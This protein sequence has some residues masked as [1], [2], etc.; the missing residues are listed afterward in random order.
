MEEKIEI[1]ILCQLYG[2][3][4][5]KKQLDM[6]EDYYNNDLSLSEIAEN[7]S[8]TRQAV[9][10]VL[11]KSKSKLYEYEDKLHLK[12]KNEEKGKN[13]IQVENLLKKEKI[14]KSTIDR[15]L[16]LIK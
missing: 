3:L 1:S 5:T 11:K 9:R 10:D 16:N 4:L 8:I 12:A 2:N 6:L 7:H 15:I 13:A 14:Q